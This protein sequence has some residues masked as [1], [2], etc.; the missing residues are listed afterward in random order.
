MTSKQIGYRWNISRNSNTP[1]DKDW[2]ALIMDENMQKIND[3]D[4][5]KFYVAKMTQRIQCNISGKLAKWLKLFG[6]YITALTLTQRGPGT[7]E[8]YL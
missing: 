5:Q 3:I 1:N 8:R 2:S 7:V 6:D 4:P